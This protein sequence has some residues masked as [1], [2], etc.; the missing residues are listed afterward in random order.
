MGYAHIENTYRNYTTTFALFRRCYALEK[1][2]GTS[3]HLSWK[4]GQVH[5]FAGGESH[6]NFLKLFDHDALKVGFE[7]M[8]H[9][10]IVVFG[11]AY[12][13]KQQGQAWRYGKQLKFVAFDVKVGDLWLDVPNACQVVT[14]RLGLEFVHYVEIDTDLVQLDFW[15]D[16]PSEQAK[17]NGVE[18]PQPR[19]GIVIRPIR[20]FRDN[21]GER[22]ISKHKSAEERET[23]TVRNVG[24]PTKLKVLEEATAI[25]DEWVTPMRLEHVL[26]KLGPVTMSDVPRIINAMVEDV[27]REG[28]GEVVDSKDARKAIGNAT[29]RFFKKRLIDAMRSPEPMIVGRTIVSEPD[30]AIQVTELHLSDSA[31]ARLNTNVSVLGPTK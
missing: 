19:E 26:D 12:G 27:L 18:G 23:K 3:A 31:K 29:V 5:F 16:A 22:I 4:D 21:S 1:I 30:A 24:D 13:G 20:E 10:E 9:P 15:R 7:S 28:A 11:E 8:G 2:H 6:Q 17:R 25:A 14:E